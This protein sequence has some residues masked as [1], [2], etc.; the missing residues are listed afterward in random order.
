[1]NPIAGMGGAVGLKG[2][3]SEA[4]LDEAVRRGARP[5]AQHRT[6]EALD[7]AD[8]LGGYEFLTAGGQMG[9]DVLRPRT[10]KVMVV[11]RPGE[12]TTESDTMAAGRAMV[13]AG[14]DLLVFTGGDG[15][16]RD[17]MDAVGE[18]VPVIGIPSGVK[19]H[20]GVFAQT[21]RA[22]GALLKRARVE[23]LPSRRTEVM[24]IDE[25]EFRQG[26]V[27][28]SLYGY[29]LSPEEPTLMQPYKMALGRGTDEEHKNAIATFFIEHMRAS[30]LYI[31]GPGTTVEAIGRK[32]GIDKTLLGV[33]L[34]ADGEIIGKDVDEDT[35]FRALAAFDQARIVISPIGAQ[36]FIF[37]RGNQQLSPRVI[38]KVGVRNVVIVATPVKM[39]GTSTLRVDTG[40]SELDDRLRGYGKVLIGYGTQLVAPIE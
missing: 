6:A 13:E 39:R 2:T 18:E 31:L 20:S 15:T 16:A 27:S 21:P 23:S 35:I 4:V 40:S 3:D 34:V 36:G 11:Y 33:D 30:T 37:G 9:E 7:A 14:I 8:G 10:S 29:M 25:E 17:V 32:L 28:A 19:M 26:R 22:A 24:D 38:E 5:Q 1:M 12:R